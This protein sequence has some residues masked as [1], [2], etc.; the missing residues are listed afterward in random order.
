MTFL[1][2]CALCASSS[3]SPAEVRSEPAGLALTAPASLRVLALVPAGPNL[4]LRYDDPS[5]SH[6]GS[7]GGDSHMGPMW[8]VMGV[9]MVA[10]M[11]A[12]GVY[13]MRG[14]F[15]ERPRPLDADAAS[16]TPT[17]SFRFGTVGPGR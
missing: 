4:A 12:A 6:G 1:L 13:M 2:V 7:H 11:A 10:M 8:V 9:M 16:A 15:N 14:G 17:V 3:S 5:A